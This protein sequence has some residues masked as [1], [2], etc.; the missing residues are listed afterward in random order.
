VPFDRSPRGVRAGHRAGHGPA[1][2][3]LDQPLD[4][5][6]VAKADLTQLRLRAS[7]RGSPIPP[8]P[9]EQENRNENA[10]DNRTIHRRSATSYEL[11]ATDRHRPLGNG[12]GSTLGADGHLDR[13]PWRGEV[14]MNVAQRDGSNPRRRRNAGDLA[15]LAIA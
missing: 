14:A 6:R 7:R 4:L 13:R 10:N 12:R 1:H 15:D 3:T 5:T 8:E 11:S 9:S 2:L